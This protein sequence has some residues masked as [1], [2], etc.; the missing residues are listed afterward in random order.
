MAAAHQPAKG[1]DKKSTHSAKRK[2]NQKSRNA[3]AVRMVPAARVPAVVE[4]MAAPSGTARF[5][6]GKELS[7]T[8]EKDPERV[9]PHFDTIAALLES[10]SKVVCWNALQIVGSLAGVDTQ[11]KIAALLGRYLAFIGGGDL[12]SAANA[13]Q[14]AGRIGRLRPELLDRIV[15]AVLAV[16]Q[17]TFKTAECG[18]V[19]AGAALEAF[20]KMGPT[21]CARNEVT[22]FIRRQMNSTRP[23]VARRAKEMA[24]ELEALD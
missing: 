19:A 14:G 22:A 20:C 5:A 7:V 2:P 24:A 11:G 9:Y 23:A 1:R 3:T 12:V 16:E 8:A 15:P 18:K 21:V 13:I 4:T 17:A 6:A 10:K